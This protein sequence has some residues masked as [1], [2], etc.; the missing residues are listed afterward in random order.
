M[1]RDDREGYGAPGSVLLAPVRCVLAVF[2]RVREMVWRDL[3]CCVAARCD[4]IVARMFCVTRALASASPILGVS[5]DAYIDHFSK[6]C[7]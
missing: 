5:G 6:P 7:D 3:T 4:A 1:R 2:K